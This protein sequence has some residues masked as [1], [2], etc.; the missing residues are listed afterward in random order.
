MATGLTIV[1]RFTYRGDSTEEFSNTYFLTGSTPA[2]DAA[3]L[4]LFNALTAQEKTLFAARVSGDALYDRPKIV[5]GYGYSSDAADRVAV[6]SRDLTA[7]TPIDGTFDALGTNAIAQ[8]GDTSAWIRWKT[9]RLTS[10]GKAIYV[11]KYYHP[12]YVSA[13]AG[14]VVQAAWRT[15]AAAFA[16]KLWDGSF[17]DGRKITAP[18]NTDTIVGAS[19]AQYTTTRTLKRR[20]KRDPS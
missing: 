1:K 9:S 10:K 11:R 12:A 6:W 3:W 13:A 5:R 17:L 4:A 7:S 2:D 8:G 19:V 14:D 16:A 18:G 15:A 20:S